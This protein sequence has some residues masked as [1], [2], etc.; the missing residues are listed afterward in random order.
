M[1]NKIY[2]TSFADNETFNIYLQ[3]KSHVSIE[4]DNSSDKVDTIEEELDAV[5]VDG[6]GNLVDL[7]RL[8]F[9]D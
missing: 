5:E 1:W 9:I 6:T 3:K 7:P 8:M 2:E 4:E